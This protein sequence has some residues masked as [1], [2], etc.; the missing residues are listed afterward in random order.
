[1]PH[2]HDEKP[3]APKARRLF[4]PDTLRRWW[5]KLVPEPD[6]SPERPASTQTGETALQVDPDIV[7]WVEPAF[8][9]TTDESRARPEPKERARTR[10]PQKRASP[11]WR[12]S[13]IA[14]RATEPPPRAKKPVSESGAALRAFLDAVEA[15]AQIETPLAEDDEDRPS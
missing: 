2:D 7:P 14:K 5:S 4:N 3:Q 1:M 8:R 11:D 9:V 10:A 12:A 6:D 13:T 15:G